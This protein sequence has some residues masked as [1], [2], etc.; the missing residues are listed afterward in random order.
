MCFYMKPFSRRVGRKGSG[1]MSSLQHTPHREA[2]GDAGDQGVEREDQRGRDAQ[3]V[4]Q[5]LL[6]P[7][8][9]QDPQDLQAARV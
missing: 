4:L 7:D 6:D 2:N 1:L 8:D 5:V 9:R 3:E